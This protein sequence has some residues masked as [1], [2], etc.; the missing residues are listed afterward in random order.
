MYYYLN[1]TLVYA[2]LNTA[3]IDC[4]GVGYRLT[5]SGTTLGHLAGKLNTE[6]RLY[7][8]LAVREDSVELFGFYDQNEKTAF[9]MLIG[10]SGVG[11]KAAVSILTLLTP[12]QLT[13]AILCEDQK[14]ISKANMVGPKTAARVILELKDKIA[15]QLS[16][17]SSSASVADIPTDQTSAVLSDAMNTLLVLGYSRPEATAA[18]RG[19][20]TG[21]AGVEDI[22]RQAL[23]RL[24]AQ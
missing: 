15:K 18:L 16:V 22:I 23:R 2:D 21:N 20:D 14:T 3:V 7:T 5:V 17:A 19:L 4:S 9:E 13:S 6:V 12:D 24:A 11:P 10:V 8:Y 1:G